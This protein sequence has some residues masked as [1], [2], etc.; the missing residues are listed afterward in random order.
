MGEAIP[1]EAM[2]VRALCAIH[3]VTELDAQQSHDIVQLVANDARCQRSKRKHLAMHEW[4]SHNCIARSVAGRA[5]VLRPVADV[6]AKYAVWNVLQM[7]LVPE[8]LAELHSRTG[9]IAPPSCNLDWRR[10]KTATSLV[11]NARV[12][13]FLSHEARMIRVVRT[14]TQPSCCFSL[15]G[16]VAT[17]GQCCNRE[18]KATM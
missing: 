4:P 3:V 1:R 11:T 7:N 6:G 15:Q 9:N 10:P 16:F 14:A 12:G 8:P 2:A 13:F 5:A 18:A 17:P